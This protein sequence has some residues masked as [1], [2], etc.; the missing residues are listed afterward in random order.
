MSRPRRSGG[1]Q[2]H[3]RSGS[4]P[5]GER[6]LV[7]LAFASHRGIR[8]FVLFACACVRLLGPCFKTGRQGRSRM[9]RRPRNRSFDL[10]GPVRI[11]EARVV[12]SRASGKRF[13]DGAT[14]IESR[15]C[16]GL[17]RPRSTTA[18]A[19]ERATSE[20]P[21]RTPARPRGFFS[22]GRFRVLFDSLF[23]VLFNFPSRYLFAVGLAVSVEPR[24]GRT[25]RL[26]AAFSNDPTLEPTR[27]FDLVARARYGPDTHLGPDP[28]GESC[29][30]SPLGLLRLPPVL[31]PHVDDRP[32]GRPDSALGSVRFSTIV[33]SL[34]SPLLRKPQLVSF[35]TA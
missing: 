19:P 16:R 5:S 12:A 1:S 34:H 25:T 3:F 18:A 23:R 14:S 15:I 8:S 30:R 17:L 28:I 13:R 10:P 27:R 2:P 29:A 31:A 35:S 9:S 32:L 7:S 20:R 26:R 24:M 11:S 4:L 22:F 21:G 6:L 33:V